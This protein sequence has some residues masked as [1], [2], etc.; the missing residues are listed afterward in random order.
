[1]GGK[2][3]PH[4]C[5]TLS[6]LKQLK[7]KVALRYRHLEVCSPSVLAASECQLHLGCFCQQLRAYRSGRHQRR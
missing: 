1:M 3:L 6:K 2:C 5:C 7:L 4:I